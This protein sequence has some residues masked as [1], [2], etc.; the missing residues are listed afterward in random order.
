MEHKLF[1]GEN[2]K[3]HLTKDFIAGSEETDNIMQIW[4]HILNKSLQKATFNQALVD[5]GSNK[6]HLITR[7]IGMNR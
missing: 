5:S 1:L 2:K 7:Y 4:H 3:C 6:N